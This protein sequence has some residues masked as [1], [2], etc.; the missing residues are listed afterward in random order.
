M[1]TNIVHKVTNPTD[2]KQLR[3]ITNGVIGELCWR[4]SL[5]YGDELSLHIGARIPYSQK[6]MTGKEKGAWILGTRAT[7][8]TI[9]LANETIT[10]SEDDSDLL[11]QKVQVIKDT[12][13]TELETSYPELSLTVTFDNGCKLI[14]LPNT[15]EDGDL[16]YWEMFTPERMILK[17]GPGAIWCYTRSD[18]LAT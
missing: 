7:A 15:Q 8:W 3:E 5:S 4:A 17:V 13:I 10:T 9:Q 16:P 12:T 1:T 14:L 6:S 2:L 11:K 18:L